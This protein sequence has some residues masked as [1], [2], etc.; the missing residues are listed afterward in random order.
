MSDDG[1]R[2]YL[3]CLP[4]GELYPWVVFPDVETEEEAWQI[5]K[6]DEWTDL[7]CMHHD[8]WKDD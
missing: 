1:P 8:I 7:V 3:Q 5:A 6:S 2:P 4:C